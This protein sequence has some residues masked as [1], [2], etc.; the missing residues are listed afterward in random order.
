MGSEKAREWELGYSAGLFNHGDPQ[1][2][3]LESSPPQLKFGEH[4]KVIEH[5]A[6]QAV[7]KERDS[8]RGILRSLEKANV[9]MSEMLR[10]A[11]EALKDISENSG[12]YSGDEYITAEKRT[13]DVALA[14]IKAWR[15]KV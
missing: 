7:V 14:K 6:Y 10:E 5:S 2:I 1:D 13:A 8:A 4:C 15:E 9:K 11:E 12:D 3:V